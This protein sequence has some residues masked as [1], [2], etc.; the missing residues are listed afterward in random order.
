LRDAI[1]HVRDSAAGRAVT[2]N[3]LMPFVRRSHVD[4]CV[5]ARIDVAVLGFGIDREMIQ[6]LTERGV[7]VFVMVGTESQALEAIACGADGLV[8]RLRSGRTPGR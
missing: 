8:A 3:L 6:R 1:Q 4:A 5:D 7:F 2:V